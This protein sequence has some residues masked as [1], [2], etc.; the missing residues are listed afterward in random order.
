MTSSPDIADQM[1]AAERLAG[2]DNCCELARHRTL[3]N[4]RLFIVKNDAITRRL[5]AAGYSQTVKK[6]I[7]NLER[8][9]TS[10]AVKHSL[11]RPGAA[12]DDRD[13]SCESDLE[14][15]SGSL[16]FRK[17]R[18]PSA[19]P[20]PADD[21][22]AGAGSS[23]VSAS[24]SGASGRSILPEAQ[25]T[26]AD[27][28]SALRSALAADGMSRPMKAAG[29]SIEESAASIDVA[30]LTGG[31]VFGDLYS[32]VAVGCIAAYLLYNSERVRGL[33]RA[34]ASLLSSRYSS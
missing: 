3:D 14:P 19:D 21:A 20:A 1:P 15:V 25:A 9:F 22:D 11:L 23:A 24:S 33:F 7:E 17:L 29:I 26:G 4:K 28:K 30:A 32:F 2:L 34:A 10:D 16:A 18:L 6:D 8:H 12:C 31:H 13:Q 5:A 27:D